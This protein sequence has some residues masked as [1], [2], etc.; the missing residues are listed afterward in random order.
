MDKLLGFELRHIGINSGSSEQAQKD[1][2]QL[3]KLLNWPVKPGTSSIFA[4]TGF[5]FLREPGRGEK[6]HIAIATNFIRRARWHL[7]QR[8]YEFDETSAKEKNGRMIAIYLKD[9]ICGFA[10]HLQQK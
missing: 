4:G 1:A 8:G 5:E 3:A 9:D 2:E 7:E 10:I 6:G